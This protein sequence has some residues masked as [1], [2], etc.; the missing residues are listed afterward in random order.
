MAVRAEAP[1]SP[2]PDLRETWRVLM[3]RKVLMLVPW[4]AAV[5][6][7]ATLA[8]LLKPI[9]FSG[10]TLLLE[11]PQALSGALGGMVSS[12]G[13][14]QQAE[15][16]REQVQS[17]LFLRS[18]ITASGVKS[19]PAT[20]AWALRHADKVPGLSPDERVEA[21]LVDYV[22]DNI[23]IRRGRGNVFQIIVG[24][25]TAERARRLAEAVANE[26]V[27]AS[28]AA[29]L[30][31][32]RATQ[33]FSVEQ[34]QIYKRKLDESEQRLESFRRAGL[35]NVMNGSSVT[36]TNATRARSLLDE[37]ALEVEEQRQHVAD[38]KQQLSGKVRENDPAL[39][40]NHETADLSGQ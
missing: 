7:G 12:I 35:S 27:I 20:R 14:E 17:S 26:F 33:E 39:L 37:A 21:F 18:V 30:E 1:P 34:Q 5:L 22:R 32:V 23:N 11:R 28:K 9:Y 25:Y 8:F 24:D 6:G 40:T 16:M 29:Q 10:V 3:R 13:P 19:D 4:S 2:P 31:A 38:L 36:E 15:V